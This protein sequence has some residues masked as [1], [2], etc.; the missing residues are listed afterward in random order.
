MCSNKVF[1]HIIY[2][3]LLLTPGFKQSISLDFSEKY[4]LCVSLQSTTP[5]LQSK[6][7]TKL[8]SKIC[9]GLEWIRNRQISKSQNVIANRELY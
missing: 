3:H 9:Y 6:N 8:T 7:D 2:G 4:F 5:G 1:R